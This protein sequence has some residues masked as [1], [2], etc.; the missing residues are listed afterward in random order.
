MTVNDKG[1][2]DNQFEPDNFLQK[3]YTTCMS[4]GC[5]CTMRESCTW[6]DEYSRQR[7]DT[8]SKDIIKEAF[9]QKYQLYHKGWMTQEYFPLD[10]EYILGKEV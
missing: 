7:R 9:K 6:C 8:Q 3:M 2:F 4:G 10:Y 1:C 5:L